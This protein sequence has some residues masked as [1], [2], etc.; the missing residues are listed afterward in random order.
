M[1]AIAFASTGSDAI[2]CT[3]GSAGGGTGTGMP[4]STL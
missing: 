1:P 2:S 4:W 3:S